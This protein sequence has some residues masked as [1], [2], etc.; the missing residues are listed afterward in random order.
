MLYQLSYAG[1]SRGLKIFWATLCVKRGG[2]IPAGADLTQAQ[3]GV[4]FGQPFINR[5]RRAI[6]N[7]RSDNAALQRVAIKSVANRPILERFTLI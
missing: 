7:K 5:P 1:K 2:R 3:W 6:V 4:G